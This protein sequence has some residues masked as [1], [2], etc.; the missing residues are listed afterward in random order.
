MGSVSD[1]N[2]QTQRGVFVTTRWT[3]VMTAAAED[4]A[5]ASR[6][7]DELCRAYWVPLYAFARRQGLSPAEAE[8][9]TQGFFARLLA[10]NDLA[11][12]NRERGRFRSFL[13]T[14][15]K[16]FLANQRRDAGRL[17]RGGGE[18]AMP[19]DFAEA[20]AVLQN[21]AHSGISPDKMFDRQWAEA[22]LDQ[23]AQ[24][25]REQYAASGKGAQADALLPF[26]WAHHEDAESAELAT[27]LDISAGAAR[28]A[29]HRARTRFRELVRGE[30]AQTVLSEAEVDAE[31]QNLIDVLRGG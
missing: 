30:I 16:N 19:L 26:L 27:R 28:V 29:L 31:L 14:S 25:F 1:A 8:D 21:A 3:M 22:V 24:R 9:A 7:L 11:H 17:K 5:P 15:F 23:A 10:R 20:E 6:A 4:R 12:A 13:I 2:S 18:A